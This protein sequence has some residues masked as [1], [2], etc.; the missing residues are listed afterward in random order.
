LPLVLLHFAHLWNHRPHYQFFPVM[1]VAV[2]WLTWKRWP[3]PAVRPAG[4]YRWG[5]FLCLSVDACLLTG[6]VLLWSP[7]LATIAGVVGIFGVLVLTA[8]PAAMR[9]L[10]PVWLLLWTVIPPPLQLD[11]DLVRYLQGTTSLLSSSG[12]EWTGVHHLRTG[13]VFQLPDRDLFVAEACSG[14]HSQL[15][16]LAACAIYVVVVRRPWLHAVC[17]LA[18]A[19]FWSVA[20]NVLR[21]TLIVLGAARFG[22]DLSGGWMHE[23]LGHV[24]LI[25]GFLLLLSTDQLL[26]GLLAPMRSDGTR[27]NRFARFWNAAIARRPAARNS[28]AIQ[29][30]ADR[31]SDVPVIREDPLPPGH[32][33]LLLCAGALIVFLPL[34]TVQTVLLLR[35]RAAEIEP[36]RFESAFAEGWLP[37]QVGDWQRRDYRLEQRDAGSD[38]GQYSQVWTYG[39]DSGGAHVSL[40]YPFSGWHELSRCYTS[41]GWRETSRTT[42]AIV[43]QSFAG[44]YV[45]VQFVKP[46]GETGS[47]LFALFD[48]TGNP[49]TPRSSHWR[50]LRARIVRSPAISL[51]RRNATPLGLTSTS[52]Q[53]QSFF[54]TANPP[55]DATSRRMRQLFF[56]CLERIHAQWRSQSH[57]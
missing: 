29:R 18:A 25:A 23:L 13:N 17:L 50:G 22:V 41:Q 5:G 52:L 57:G 38:E 46:T 28:A 54:V 55:D 33:G 11:G 51:F 20:M 44:Q 45:E 48:A 47:L 1:L 34:V 26:A 2:A 24:L 16:L 30:A 37:D 10:L 32:R 31:P 36:R 14:I 56:G 15:V 7:W 9:S 21:V 19:V 4:V 42:H 27:R 6:A 35:E 43:K 8:G 53:V 12:L 3:R 40:D 39:S 49:L